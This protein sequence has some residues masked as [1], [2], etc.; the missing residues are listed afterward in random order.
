[1]KILFFSSDIESVFTRSFIDICKHSNIEADIVSFKDRYCLINGKE[2][3]VSTRIFKNYYIEFFFRIFY[4]I[5]I[6]TKLPKYDI[7][8]L[9]GWKEEFS[10]LFLL[11][12]LKSRRIILTIFGPNTFRIFLKRFTLRLFKKYIGIINFTSKDF[13]KKHSVFFKKDLSK[14]CIVCIPLNTFLEI[15]KA[16]ENVNKITKIHI[17]CS[18]NRAITT[19][20]LKIIEQVKNLNL[21]KDLIVFTFL[22]TYGTDDQEYFKKVCKEIEAELHDFEYEIY[23]DY[24]SDIEL[25]K[26]R[27]ENKIFINLR[28][29]DQFAGAM[30]EALYSGAYVITGTWLP[31][32]ELTDYGVFFRSIDSTKELADALTEVL[33]VIDSTEITEKLETNR[34][35]M[36]SHFHPDIITKK[37]LLLYENILL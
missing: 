3:N 8:H 25:A 10:V 31:Y 32:S 7:I 11:Y 36:Y 16:R 34:T 17:S 13:Y 28:T 29:E 27:I 19:N 1:M 5:K 12:K 33:S 30:L 35:I 14:I 23:T 20:H 4:G 18:T 9:L 6:F 2:Q 26:Y 37:W 21:Y 15:D 24:M 22:M